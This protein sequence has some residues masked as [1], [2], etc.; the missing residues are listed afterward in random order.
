MYSTTSEG[1]DDMQ[2]R[3]PLRRFLTVAAALTSLAATVAIW[4]ELHG[5]AAGAAVTFL[6][7]AM[8]YS[9]LVMAAA[10]AVI[11]MAKTIA[12]E[13]QDQRA[14]YRRATLPAASFR[15]DRSS[16]VSLAYFR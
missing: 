8:G 9:V 4:R 15:T 12:G 11:A 3:S 1:N 2:E 6:A 13:I 14:W 7:G 16:P 10:I 5:Q